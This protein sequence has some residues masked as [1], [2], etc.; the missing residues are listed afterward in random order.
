M[1]K[2]LRV[3][4]VEDSENDALLL[5]RELKRAGYEPVHERVYTALDMNTALEK[6]YWDVIISDFVM[7]QFSGLEALKLVQGKRLDIPFIIT[8]G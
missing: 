5:L 7:P 4:I 1:D 8:S 2:P 3:L 6:Q